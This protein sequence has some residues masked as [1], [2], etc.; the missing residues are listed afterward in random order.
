[1]I[2]GPV[3]IRQ[4]ALSCVKKSSN[5]SLSCYQTPYGRAAESMPPNTKFEEFCVILSN[6]ERSRGGVEGSVSLGF[7]K[8]NGFFG[9][10]AR[11]SE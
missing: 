1:M 11:P 5:C 10:A 9:F 8:K 4:Q 6:P 3:A 7:D 2:L